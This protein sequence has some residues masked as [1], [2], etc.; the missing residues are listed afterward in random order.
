VFWHTVAVVIGVVLLFY[1]VVGCAIVASMLHSPRPPSPRPCP[2]CSVSL[3]EHG[4]VLVNG[5]DHWIVACEMC[6]AVSR[7]EHGE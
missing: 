4:R 3:R 7:W 6:N 1:V 2:A 5:E